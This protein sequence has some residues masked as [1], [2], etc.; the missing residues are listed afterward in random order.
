MEAAL[1]QAIGL[2]GFE[3]RLVVIS[4]HSLEDRIVKQVMQRES[5]GDEARLGLIRKKVVTPSLA[6]VELNPRSRSAKLRIA[7]RT[8]TQDEYY[9]TAEKLRLS[10]ETSGGWRRAASLKKLRRTFET[11]DRGGFENVKNNPIHRVK[12]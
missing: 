8:V 3:G 1:K 7:E 12:I 2:L 4:Y 5:K 6:E 10:T 9:T 11:A